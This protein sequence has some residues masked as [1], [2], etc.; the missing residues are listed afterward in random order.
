[1]DSESLATRLKSLRKRRGLSLQKVGDL[2]GV[3]KN[4]VFKWESEQ[5]QPS[6][7]NLS[8]LAKT[9]EVEPVFLAYGVVESKTP[10]DKLIK[11]I[12]LLD[13]AEAALLLSLLDKMLGPR[14]YQDVAGE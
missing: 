13:D 5:A 6:V 4:S 14:K 12:S 9:F 8:A 2:I 11:K 10:H 1:M 3:S 7:K